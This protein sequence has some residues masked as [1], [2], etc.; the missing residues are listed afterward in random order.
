M[1]GASPYIPSR[2]T[3]LAQVAGSSGS[4]PVSRQRMARAAAA[5]SP[6]KASST[7][8]NPSSMNWSICALVSARVRSRE[9]G[10]FCSHVFARQTHPLRA[11]P[12][13]DLQALGAPL[14]PLAWASTAV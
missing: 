14:F 2:I 5:F 4:H 13:I 6:A 9:V 10:M 3:G 7:R 8:T 1:N 12:A 11:R